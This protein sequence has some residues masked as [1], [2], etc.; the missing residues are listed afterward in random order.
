MSTNL[1]WTSATQQTNSARQPEEPPTQKNNALLQALVGV[2]EHHGLFKDL[3]ANGAATAPELARRTGLN[4]EFVCEWLRAVAVA[5]RLEHD[6]HTRRF[7]LPPGHPYP[8][9]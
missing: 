9:D 5:G 1:V 6:A 3:A 4:E 7:A 2:G 8:S